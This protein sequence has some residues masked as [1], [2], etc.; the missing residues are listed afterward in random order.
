MP[1]AQFFLTKLKKCVE[2]IMKRK[3]DPRS[4]SG[5]C[6]CEKINNLAIF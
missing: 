3:I 4:V 5:A 1:Y 6:L 2:Q